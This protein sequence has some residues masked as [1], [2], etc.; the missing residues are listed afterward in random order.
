MSS[1]VDSRYSVKGSF[2]ERAV[3]TH[4]TE[5]HTFEESA[6]LHIFFTPPQVARMVLARIERKIGRGMKA[7]LCCPNEVII[8]GRAIAH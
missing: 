1:T 4:G 5:K 3:R 2:R 7:P 6:M 8:H